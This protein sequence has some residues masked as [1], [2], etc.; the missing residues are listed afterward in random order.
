MRARKNDA[1]LA[2]QHLLAL[3][4]DFEADIQSEVYNRHLPDDVARKVAQ[5]L[6]KAGL[7]VKAAP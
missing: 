7:D 5:G 3:K 2:V 4:P 6:L 1:Q